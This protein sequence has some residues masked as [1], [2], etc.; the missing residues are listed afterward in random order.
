MVCLFVIIYM[1]DFLLVI[2]MIKEE[3]IKIDGEVKLGATIAY[4]E[5]NEKRPVVILIGGTGSLDRDGNGF[6]VKMNLYKQLS[7]EFV[8]NGYICIRYDKRGTHESEKG[9]SKT[10]L[11]DLVND[12]ISVCKYAKELD[13]VDENKVVVCGHSEGVMVATLLSR[14]ED[15]KGLILLSGAGTSLKESMIHQNKLTIKQ[16]KEGKGFNNFIIRHLVKEDKVLKQVEDIYAKANSA[17]KDT[18]SFKGVPMGTMYMREHGALTGEDYTS[19]LKEYKGE[20]LAIT[21]KKDLQA[22]YKRLVLLE[23]ISNASIHAPDNVNHILKDVYGDNSIMNVKKQYLK[24]T[25]APLSREVIDPIMG[26]MKTKIDTSILLESEENNIVT[27]RNIVVT[28][29][30]VKENTNTNTK[31]R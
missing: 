3:R 15:V 8:N 2:Y 11:T 18:Y 23:G 16:A 12:A 4:T 22:D 7:D 14:K 17:K 24:L 5:V 27:P 29:T 25:S 21:G 20:I 28:H 31:K 13:I 30:K 9:N 19:Y 1:L 6:G 26:W 10:S